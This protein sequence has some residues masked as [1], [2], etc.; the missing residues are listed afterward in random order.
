MKKLYLFTGLLLANITFAQ[1]QTQDFEAATLPAGWTTNIVSGSVD[2]TFGSGNMS[3]GTDF[4]TNAAIFDDDAAG[5]F[6]LD[7]TV[8]LLSPTIDVSAATSL[9]L[10]FDYAL[11]DYIGSGYMTA[12]VWDGSAWIEILNVTEDTNP[13]PFT[14]DVLQYANPAFQ[15]RYTYDDD[16]DYAWGAGVDNFVLT[17]TLA[18]NTFAQ[19]KISVSP[20]PSADF[21]NIN[22]T[23]VI[24]NIRI[25]DLS[26]KTVQD[27]QNGTNRVDI[28]NLSTGTYF[29]KYDTEGN[30]YLNR[31]VKK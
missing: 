23:D 25:V 20:N 2:W 29:L 6:E 17:G 24:T 11:Q 30:H 16:D 10:S 4:P 22:T 8:Q 26:G 19:S 21:I 13:T 12:E 28:T 1:L 15:V 9:N 18:N 31:I 5:E 27:I 7:N 14:L 3:S